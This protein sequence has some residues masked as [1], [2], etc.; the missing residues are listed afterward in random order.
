MLPIHEIVLH[1][2]M[3]VLFGGCLLWFFPR[4][5]QDRARQLSGDRLR[6]SVRLSVRAVSYA[7]AGVGLSGWVRGEE[8]ALQGLALT[9]FALIPLWCGEIELT[10]SKGLV[11]RRLL[12]LW[13]SSIQWDEVAHAV[14]DCEVSGDIR[15]RQVIVVAETAG[16]EIVHHDFWH[17]DQ[18]RLIAELER[19]KRFRVTVTLNGVAPGPGASL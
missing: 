11:K 13:R 18:E 3:L 4:V 6:F 17:S 2:S 16:R 15:N 5:L 7:L 12:G 10:R 19:L 14:T 8:D 9:S 1:L